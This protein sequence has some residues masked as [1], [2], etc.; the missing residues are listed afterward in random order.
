MDKKEI[1]NWIGK[2]ISI[3]GVGGFITIDSESKVIT[4]FCDQRCTFHIQKAPSKYGENKV[5]FQY[6][7]RERN[8][9]T[10]EYL[11]ITMYGD[12]QKQAA[13]QALAVLPIPSDLLP[14]IVNM[15]VGEATDGNNFEG[16]G[17]NYSA[18]TIQSGPPSVLQVFEIINPRFFSNH[19]PKPYRKMFHEKAGVKSI[20]GTYWRS[21]HWDKTVTQSPHLLRDETWVFRERPKNS[22]EN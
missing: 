22:S 11:T 3:K 13:L 7:N 8:K 20:F 18:M 19:V 5:M 1:N 6:C 14:D 10:R 12:K 17:F 21:Q 15:T 4:S 9:K 16:A 2:E